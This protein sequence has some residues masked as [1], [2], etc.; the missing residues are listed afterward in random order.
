MSKIRLISLP[1]LPPADFFLLLYMHCNTVEIK[2]SIMFIFLYIFCRRKGGS[3][4]KS[5]WFMEMIE[6]KLLKDQILQIFLFNLSIIAS[7][8]AVF[9]GTKCVTVSSATTPLKTIT[10]PFLHKSPPCKLRLTWPFNS[11][12]LLFIRF[13]N[14]LLLSFGM[15]LVV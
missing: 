12:L 13:M 14:N 6:F 7:S 3:G 15:L 11:R 2:C 10:A 1:F 8:H 5:H 4:V 9:L